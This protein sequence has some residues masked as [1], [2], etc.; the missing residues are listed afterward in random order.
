M[1]DLGFWELVLIGIVG[2]L[3]VGPDRLPGFARELGRWVRKIRHL[4]SDAR[5]ELQRELQWDD[6]DDPRRDVDKAKNEL[7]RKIN[8]LDQLMQQ[9]PDRQ[10]GWQSEYTANG[11]KKR[12]VDSGTGDTTEKTGEQ[13]ADTPKKDDSTRRS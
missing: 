9:A 6:N 7:G 2:L 5:R 11:R 12:D 8:D 1:F 13:A 3:V 10:P 4:S